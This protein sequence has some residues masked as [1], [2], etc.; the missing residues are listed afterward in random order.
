MTIFPLDHS[1]MNEI[2]YSMENQKNKSYIKIDDGEIIFS[3]KGKSLKP[4]RTLYPLPKW[5]PIE[6]FR[7]MNDFV[8]HLN[9]PLLK[10]E[11]SAVLNAGHG[12]FRKFKN[13]LKSSPEVEKVWFTF[14]KGEMKTHVVNWY[15][16]VREYVG[17]DQL[18]E[19]ELGADPDILGFDFT[20]ELGVK[21]NLKYIMDGDRKG[22]EELYSH[23]AIDVILDIYER[24][25]EGMLS[26][27]MFNNDD[28]I[29]AKAPTG[30]VVGFIWAIGYTLG[31]SYSVMELLQLYVTPEL[32]GLGIGKALLG[33]LLI[34]YRDGLYK[35]FVA[36]PYNQSSWIIKFLELEKFQIVSQ[37]LCFRS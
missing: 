17:L 9:N 15:N 37:E 23:Y 31:E 4:D 2:L 32:R 29:M 34:K 14:K 10:E 33:E 28:I 30:E 7:I 1:K 19:D 22:F 11:L 35:E 21:E 6:G 5:G 13:V 25:R 12:V 24:K 18:T 8:F 27:D 20:M 36:N 3:E 26:E 16:Q